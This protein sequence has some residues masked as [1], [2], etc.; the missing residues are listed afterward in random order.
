M[1]WLVHRRCQVEEGKTLSLPPSVDLINFPGVAWDPHHHGPL[2]SGPTLAQAH[3]HLR[4][5]GSLPWSSSSLGRKSC[6]ILS[7][8][9]QAGA[10]LLFRHMAGLSQHHPAPW[11]RLSSLLLPLAHSSGSCRASPLCVP[12]R[13]DGLNDPP[14]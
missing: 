5:S 8:P 4:P 14:L 13:H 7:K 12:G 6:Q 2:G 10:H 11:P 9:P 1:L 3:S